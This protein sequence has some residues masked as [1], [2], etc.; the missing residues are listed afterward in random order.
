MVKIGNLELPAFPVLLAPME[1]ITDP[2]FRKLCREFGADMVYTEFV[3]SEALIRNI[4]KSHKKLEFNNAERPTGAQIFGN[5]AETM[6]QAAILAETYKPDLI[7]LNFGCPVK[8]IIAKGCGAALL[9]TPELMLEIVKA[10]K[11]SVSL[12]VTVKTRL[13]WDEKSKIIVEIAE[14]LQDCGI[15]AISI[16]GR[17]KTQMYQGKADWQLIGEVKN[18]PRMKIPVFGNGDIDSPEK[19]LEMK[20]KFGVDGIMIGRASIGNPWIFKEIK[21]F[22]QTG[23]LL[24]PPSFAERISVCK[25]LLV[26]SVSWKSEHRAVQEMRKHYTGFFRGMSHFKPWRIQLMLAK[27]TEEALKILDDISL[28]Y[29]EKAK[30]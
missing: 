29:S 27:T 24:P 19:A 25:K 4:N 6:R 16:H 30:D 2:P 3:S 8:K 21:H 18:N 23:E 22:L 14:R 28:N 7:D 15:A 10:V 5:S 1:D 17:T 13:G 12:P 9:K 20:N 11:V 26:E